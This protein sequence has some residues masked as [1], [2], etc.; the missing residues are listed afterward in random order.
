M[1]EMRVDIAE[2]TKQRRRL[3]EELDDLN[4][5]HR[6]INARVDDED[7]SFL[8]VVYEMVKRVDLI[9]RLIQKAKDEKDPDET[10]IEGLET[11]HQS[12]DDLYARHN[13]KQ[14]TIEP[15]TVLVI[16]YEGPKG[17]PGMREMLS[18]TAAI[19]GHGNGEKVA[20]LMMAMMTLLKTSGIHRSLSLSRRTKKVSLMKIRFARSSSTL[21][22]R[23]FKV[24]WASGSPAMSAKWCA[25]RSAWQLR[26]K[27]SNNPIN[28]TG[29][30]ALPCG[31]R[32]PRA[33]VPLW[34]WRAAKR[35]R[36]WQ[37]AVAPRWRHPH[38]GEGW[39]T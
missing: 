12:F 16:R 15:G 14:E 10:L 11:I 8:P 27:T 36:R 18:V 7:D 39:V 28:Q 6:T 32:G 1:E 5:R 21:F 13:I 23:N 34:A 3:R 22:A 33:T 9:E 20:L 25:V 31:T 26:Q 38:V 30:A 37:R 24:C 17:G 29:F 19:Y 2:L 35:L 4:D